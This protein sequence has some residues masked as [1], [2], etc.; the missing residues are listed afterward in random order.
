[1]VVNFGS[2]KK[3]IDLWSRGSMTQFFNW[4]QPIEQNYRDKTKERRKKKKEIRNIER[5]KQFKGMIEKEILNRIV[6]LE[7]DRTRKIK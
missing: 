4:D 3:I 7:N 2:G 6:I 5:K 1:M